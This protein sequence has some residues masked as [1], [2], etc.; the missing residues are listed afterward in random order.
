MLA[1]RSRATIGGGRSTAGLRILSK[2]EPRF[3]YLTSVVNG[4]VEAATAEE[5]EL[6]TAGLSRLPSKQSFVV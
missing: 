3:R 2:T 4:G 5:I 1:F 6:S